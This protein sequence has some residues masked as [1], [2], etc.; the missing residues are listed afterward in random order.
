MSN[1]YGT[2]PL[3]IEGVQVARAVSGNAAAIRAGTS[4][5][6]TFGGKQGVTIAPGGQMDSDPI[7]FDVAAHQPL[8]V[9]TYMGAGQ[10]M[11]GVAQGGEPD[12]LRIDARQPFLRYRRRRVSHPIYAI[13][14]ADE[15]FRR[16]ARRRARSWRSATR[17][18]TACAPRRTQNRR[19]PDA[20]ARRLTQKGIDSTAVVNAG[21][22]GNRLL[23]GSPCYGDALLNRFDRDALRQPGRARR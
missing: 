16:Y 17:S 1:V 9:S 22:S 21:I 3:V 6:V 8:A 7:A 23:S 14:V 20:L 15:R 5:A 18:P 19:W 4:R 12:E 2:A 10:K 13:R 11:A